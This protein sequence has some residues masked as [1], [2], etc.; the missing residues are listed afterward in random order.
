MIASYVASSIRRSCGSMKFASA[1]ATPKKSASNMSMFFSLPL[2]VGKPHMPVGGNRVCIAQSSTSSM[3]LHTYLQASDYRQLSPCPRPPSG[4]SQIPRN[5]L[6]AESGPKR[7]K[8]Q[9]MACSSCC[10]TLSKSHS[11]LDTHFQLRSAAPNSRIVAP[12]ANDHASRTACSRTS[13]EVSANLPTN[14]TIAVESAL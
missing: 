2:R 3:K 9:P 7:P 14:E 12:T 11:C 4:C 13:H 6:I 1:S 5:C 8:P 10:A